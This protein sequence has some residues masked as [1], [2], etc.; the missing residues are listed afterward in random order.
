MRA[1]TPGVPA[2]PAIGSRA[3]PAETSVC[4]RTLLAARLLLL[5]LLLTELLVLL[6]ELGGFG[7]SLFALL[8]LVV[9]I[10][11]ASAERSAHRRANRGPRARHPGESAEQG[12]TRSTRRGT[13]A[14][15]ADRT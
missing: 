9:D 13:D 14:G 3:K 5:L 4:G 1:V 12:A 15:A 2:A 7:L 10:A 11:A 8:V 6:A